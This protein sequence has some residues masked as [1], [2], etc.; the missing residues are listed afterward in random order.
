MGETHK[1]LIWAILWAKAGEQAGGAQAVGRRRGHAQDPPT[2]RERA[3]IAEASRRPE[4]G[5]I[6]M[7]LMASRKVDYGAPVGRISTLL[8]VYVSLVFR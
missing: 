2:R 3:P 6:P 8:S 4:T 7:L 1:V 5:T